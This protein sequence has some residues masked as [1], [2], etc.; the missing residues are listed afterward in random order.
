MASELTPTYDRDTGQVVL[1]D[2]PTGAA[3]GAGLI[4]VP[5]LELTFDRADGRLARAVVDT[6]QPGRPM[7]C[8]EAFPGVLRALFGPQAPD[9]V[10]AAAARRGK[11][12][13]LSAGTRISATWSR[14]ARLETARATSPCRLPHC[15]QQR[16]HSSPKRPAFTTGRGQ[17]PGWQPTAWS[18]SSAPPPS[19]R[20]SHRRP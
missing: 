16:P 18:N 7:I 5:G 4:P 17:K 10:R 1:E 6:A 2:L 9:T 11:Q 3:G 12:R 15:G 14:L 19:P 13:G 8:G 20:R